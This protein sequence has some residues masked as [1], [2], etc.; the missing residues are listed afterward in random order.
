LE[1]YKIAYEKH[2]EYDVLM[3]GINNKLE[4]QDY[5]ITVIKGGKA[6]ILK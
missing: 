4:K 6:K 1:G 2:K 5:E 3:V